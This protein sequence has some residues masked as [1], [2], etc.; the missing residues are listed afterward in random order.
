M[1][2]QLAI[3][4]DG[5]FLQDVRTNTGQWIAGVLRIEF[6]ERRDS[7]PLHSCTMEEEDVA[8]TGNLDQ[9]MQ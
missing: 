4:G 1:S 7:M 9:V 8:R 2:A 3:D 6:K 5:D